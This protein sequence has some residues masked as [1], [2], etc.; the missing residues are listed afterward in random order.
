MMF[1]HYMRFYLYA[2]V[3]FVKRFRHRH[4]R[5]REFEHLLR[6]VFRFSKTRAIYWSRWIK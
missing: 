2:I 5:K 4:L 3:S 1:L 6:Y